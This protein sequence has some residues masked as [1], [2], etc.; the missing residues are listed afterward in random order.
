MSDPISKRYAATKTPSRLKRS[1]VYRSARSLYKF[2]TDAQYRSVALI[3]LKRPPNLF[4]PF[5]DTWPDRYPL[6]FGF[7]R[8]TLGAD[9][10]A[11]VL[12]FGCSTGEEVFTLRRYLP[13]TVIKGL[14][15]NHRAIAICKAQL[16][17]SPDTQITFDVANSTR[18]EK[19]GTYDAIFCLAVLR[20]GDLG[21]FGADHCD[22]VIRFADFERMVGDFSRCL[23]I[24][25]LLFVAH[26]NFRFCDTA[27][28][29]SF[30]VALRTLS[31]IADPGTPIFDRNN[32]RLDGAAYG[33]LAFRKV[34]SRGPG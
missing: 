25:G 19:A 24:G 16:D 2:A 7:A 10:E 17:R 11:R 14:D 18:E 21:A 29:D 32:R 20:H 33:E 26:S 6:L 31:P 8:Q 34:R 13:K 23:K 22:D 5:I 9:A 28:S 15:I 4:Q 30:E 12:S 3:R 27:V 1:L